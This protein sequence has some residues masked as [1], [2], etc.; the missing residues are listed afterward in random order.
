MREAVS[1]SQQP[2]SQA[3]GCITCSKLLP[4]CE[5]PLQRQV[6]QIW[7]DANDDFH[8]EHLKFSWNATLTELDNEL[9]FLQVM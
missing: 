5:P 3:W 2:K 9:S 1:T 7:S 6:N 8:V 4:T